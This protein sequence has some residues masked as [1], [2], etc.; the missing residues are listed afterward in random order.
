[1]K[2]AQIQPYNIELVIVTPSIVNR[3][4]EVMKMTGPEEAAILNTL[5]SFTSSPFLAWLG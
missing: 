2:I 3:F 4:F 5:G 1:M